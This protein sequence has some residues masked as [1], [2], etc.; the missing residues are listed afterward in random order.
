MAATSVI[1]LPHGL[2]DGRR[3]RSSA[4]LRT[5]TGA[6]EAYLLSGGGR[7]R[8]EQVTALLGRCL[9]RVDDVPAGDALVRS[10][11][12]GDREALLLHLRRITVG[13]PLPCLIGCP[14]CG[15]TMEL[16]LSTRALLLPPYEHLG[17]WH[18]L[19]GG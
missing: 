2:W 19:G 16:D 7:S 9:V 1:T 11:T 6:D 10:L 13:D 18:P 4:E 15:A 14:A 12:V 8:A 17:E 3:R 5:P